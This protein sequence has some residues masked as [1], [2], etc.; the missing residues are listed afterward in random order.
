MTGREGGQLKKPKKTPPT[1]RPAAN[2]FYEAAARRFE[3]L[4]DGVPVACLTFDKDGKVFEWNQAAAELWERPAHDA[5]QQ[6]IDRVLRRVGRSQEIWSAVDRVF[7]GESVLGLEWRAEFEDGREKWVVANAFPI[8]SLEGKITGAILAGVDITARRKLQA[9]VES[10][11]LELNQAHSQLELQRDELAEANAKLEGLATID[12]LT[13]VKNHRAFQ[14]FLEQQFQIC[15]RSMTPLSLLLL[16]VDKFKNVNDSHGHQTGD[17]VLRRLAGVLAHEARKSDFVARYGGEEFVVV[18]PNTHRDGAGEAAERL[19]LA[20]EGQK[21]EF[22]G[23]TASFGC[24][25]MRSEDE[26]REDLISRADAALY[27]SK[28]T[29]RNRVSHSDQLDQAA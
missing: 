2:E 23:I 9:L 15:R 24:S 8:R 25:T 18:L 10:Q 20:V 6:S 27:L 26:S 29:G 21:F 16:D 5:F 11:L 28:R 19:R 13:G 4:F 22:G 1:E 12:G 3:A 17:D 14:E 7:N